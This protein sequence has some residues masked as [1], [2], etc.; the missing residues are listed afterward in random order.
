MLHPHTELRFISPEIGYGVV[1]TRFIPR[2]TITWARCDLDQSFTPR[3]LTQM[4]QEYQAILEKYCFRDAKGDHILCWD[5]ARFINHS[6]DAT[7]LSPGYNFEIAVRDIQAGE[8]LTDDYGTLNLDTPFQCLCRASGCRGTVAPEDVFTQADAW[9]DRVRAAFPPLGHVDQPLWGVVR[10]KRAV[11][12][13]L[14]QPALMASCKRHFRL[15]RAAEAPGKS[16][17]LRAVG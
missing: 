15:L 11:K 7:C 1:A 9:D 12:A 2:G 4:G 13:A 6:C 8:E 5:L 16:V 14:A 17:G 3:R 10:E